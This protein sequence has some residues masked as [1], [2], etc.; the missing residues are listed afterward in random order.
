MWPLLLQVIEEG[1]YGHQIKQCC[2][3][4][5]F[6]TNFSDD[7]II[8]WFSNGWGC[9][10][11][12]LLKHLHMTDLFTRGRVFKMDVENVETGNCI[13][14]LVNDGILRSTAWK[15]SNEHPA[16]LITEHPTCLY[17]L[18]CCWFP[19]SVVTWKTF[20]EEVYTSQKLQDYENLHRGDF[21]NSLKKNIWQK[22]L[23]IF[24][25]NITEIYLNCYFPMKLL[26]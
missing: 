17:F 23:F 2:F 15:N 4:I 24:N 8:K 19:P 9:N 5:F 10:F 14:T 22:F 18:Q 26:W 13:L 7:S 12:L 1:I 16:M 11:H 20:L 21:F 25:C 6:N 3:L